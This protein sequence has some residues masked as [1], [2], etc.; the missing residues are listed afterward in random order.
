MSVNT[1]AS[2]ANSMAAAP[3]E[4]PARRAKKRCSVLAPRRMRYP[5]KMRVISNHLILFDQLRGGA[6]DRRGAKRGAI[7]LKFRTAGEADRVRDDLRARGGRAVAAAEAQ[8]RPW[9][10]DRTTEILRAAAG[11]VKSGPNRHLAVTIDHDALH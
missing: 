5:G 2:R 8:V 10:V 7:N 1:G 4:S 3:L 6:A 9:Q 11:Q